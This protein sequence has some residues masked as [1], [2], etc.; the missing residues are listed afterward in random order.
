M[1]AA[2]DAGATHARSN[3]AT[4]GCKLRLDYTYSKAVRSTDIMLAQ[5]PL[6]VAASCRHPQS[7]TTTASS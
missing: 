7:A 1:S 3:A 5:P 4:A 6:I 2:A